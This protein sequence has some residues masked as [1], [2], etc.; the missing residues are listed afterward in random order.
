M[1]DHHQ[2]VYSGS[3][4]LPLQLYFVDDVQKLDY[5]LQRNVPQKPYTFRCKRRVPQADRIRRAGGNM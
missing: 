4:V 3:N 2:Q 5:L 1:G